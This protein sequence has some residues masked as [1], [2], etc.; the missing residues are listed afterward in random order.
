MTLHIGW[1]NHECPYC[2][3]TFIPF[4][5]SPVCP[6]CGQENPESQEYRGFI[7]KCATSLYVNMLRYGRYMPNGWGII[8]YSDQV[9]HY[10]FKIFDLIER[11]KPA[12]AQKYVEHE[13]RFALWEQYEYR[14]L[15]D[16][17][18]RVYFE[19]AQPP[20]G[21]WE[22]LL[23]F[24]GRW[25]GDKLTP[26][27]PTVSV[28]IPE[29]YA[30]WHGK[31]VVVARGMSRTISVFAGTGDEL[32]KKAEATGAKL[33]FAEGSAAN[34][35]DFLLA[36]TYE[37]TIS[38]AGELALPRYLVFHAGNS[39]AFDVREVAHGLEIRATI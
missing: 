33:E 13:W 16:I 28:R 30:A 20:S 10:L 3:V 26:L 23:R 7:S 11:D 15:L 24:R 34:F 1:E 27:A 32:R 19:L 35:T 17:F 14:H 2:N 25:H 38:S 12:D 8:N 29:Q 18:L 36:S 22:H 9:Q 37:S 31:T 4:G 39:T 6:N 5:A 21:F